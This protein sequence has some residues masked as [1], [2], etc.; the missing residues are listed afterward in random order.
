MPTPGRR[1]QGFT[2]IE[3]MIV[4][5]IISVLV[6]IAIPKFAGLIRKS[7]EAALKGH[8]GSARSALTIYYAEAEGYYPNV[9]SVA[10]I[11]T[12]LQSKY[13]DRFRDDLQVPH[14]HTG[15]QLTTYIF[16]GGPVAN[17]PGVLVDAFTD[18]WANGGL[19]Y[20]NWSLA[21]LPPTTVAGFRMECFH[22]DLRNVMWSMN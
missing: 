19:T 15:S 13:I 3:L 10:Q 2:L 11:K 6:M 14:H 18:T 22:T 4:S 16:S 17:P 1:Q 9:A 12:V 7:K 5:T 21:G 20:W 8:L